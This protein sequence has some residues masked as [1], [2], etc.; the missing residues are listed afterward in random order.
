MDQLTYTI[1]GRLW[2][3]PAKAIERASA[4]L[5]AAGFRTKSSSNGSTVFEGPGM[6]STKQS[7]LL[8]A[9]RIRLRA[10]GDKLSLEAELGGARKLGLF[11]RIFPPALCLF[12]GL[13]FTIIMSAQQENTLWMLPLYTAL[14]LMLVVWLIIGPM[15]ARRIL[16][17]SRRALDR[18]VEEVARH[19]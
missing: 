7:P 10:R 9:S 17:S 12:L 15:I 4:T 18:L 11:A 8:G 13:V 19:D 1:G 5:T 2:T 6:R 3:D 16:A 14:G